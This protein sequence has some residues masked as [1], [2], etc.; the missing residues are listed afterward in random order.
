MLILSFNRSVFAEQLISQ[1]L[2]SIRSK[3]Y[4]SF[5][6][7][8]TAVLLAISSWAAV[9][10]GLNS[11][12]PGILYIA[13]FVASDAV[14]YWVMA[15]LEEEWTHSP[16]LLTYNEGLRCVASGLFYVLTKVYPEAYAL[17]W[18]A[19]LIG[20][21]WP[22]SA[23]FLFDRL[24]FSD[25]WAYLKNK[26][27]FEIF[28]AVQYLTATGAA[29]LLPLTALPVF[30]TSAFGGMRLAQSSL[31]PLALLGSAL[32]PSAI[33]SFSKLS[34]PSRVGR[35][36]LRALAIYFA[37][38]VVSALG[39]WTVV[40]TTA[41]HWLPADQVDTVRSVSLPII[42]SL[43]LVLVGQPGGAVIRTMRLGA[44]SLAGQLFGISWACVSALYV[45]S[46]SGNLLNFVW[47]LSGGTI[48]T[49]VGTYVLLFVKLYR[50]L[51]SRRSNGKRVRLGAIEE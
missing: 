14:R 49:V 13:G 3:G 24:R 23:I 22:V 33:K 12:I 40:Q 10:M 17:V 7:A 19:V 43:A 41:E 38:S 37:V 1:G 48:A 28:M 42:A 2:S 32:Q 26:S 8:W 47:A 25:T 18:V 34:R 50:P 6:F 35:Q 30:G 29:Q 44:L 5:I 9:V 51:S 15:H 45:F 20:W 39:A 27:R 16:Y 46:N 36:L 31:A 21:L 4:G 11:A